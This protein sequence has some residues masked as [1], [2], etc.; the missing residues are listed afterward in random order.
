M[1]EDEPAA[2]ELLL[3]YAAADPRLDVVGHARDGR[4]AVELV[5][6]RRP[7]LLLLDVEMP[8][9]DG[10]GVLAELQAS[11]T[12]VPRVVFVTAFDRYAVRAFD[13]HA[14]DYLLKPVTPARFRDAIG[15]CLPAPPPAVAAADLAGDALRTPPRRLLVRDRGRIVPLPVSD[16][17]WLE[18]EGDYVRLHVAGRSHLVERTLA[19]MEA[20]LAACGFLR[21][22]RGAIVNAERV[23]QLHPE[24]SGRY[25]LV[26]RDG[27]ELV[28][29]RSYSQ[30]FREA[31]L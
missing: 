6:A 13:V 27:T 9:L 7:Q 30:R 19:Q 14:V 22:H 29:S 3:R 17:D 24:G 8:V 26:L 20:L 23:A 31:A 25:R 18:A 4:S 11:G 10:F 1:A 2:A 15:R 16:V 5:R 12:E 28:V 21:I